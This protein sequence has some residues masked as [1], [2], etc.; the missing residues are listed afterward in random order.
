M[1][2]TIAILVFVVGIFVGFINTL[3]GSGSLLSLPM[4]IFAG[5]PPVVA[6]GT[7]R[8]SILLQ[9]LVGLLTF[10]KEKMLDVRNAFLLSL[11]AVPGAIAGSLIAVDIP[12]EVMK[13]FIGAMIVFFIII[14]IINP[15]RFR[16]DHKE[17]YDVKLKWFH[18]LIFVFIG[19]YGGFIQAGVGVFMLF[20]LTLT[21]GYD[22]VRANAIKLA[23][24]FVFTPFAL[25]TFIYH[26]QVEWIPGLVLAGGSMIGA[27]IAAKLAIKKGSAAIRYVLLIALAASAVKLFFF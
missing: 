7:N 20:A 4:L 25:A 21:A 6:N 18:Y 14:T 11:A 10:R 2:I 27:W 16:K 5:L 12:D 15:K 8:I 1:D 3:A 17:K 24:T 23:L 26:D 22:L 13:T 19:A 9:T